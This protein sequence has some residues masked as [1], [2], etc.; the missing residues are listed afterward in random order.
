[1]WE[2]LKKL[3]GA[4]SNMANHTQCFIK[5]FVL[6]LGSVKENSAGFLVFVK[7]NNKFKLTGAGGIETIDLCRDVIY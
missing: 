6:R 5:M 7:Q 3:L 1:M 4:W 2:D